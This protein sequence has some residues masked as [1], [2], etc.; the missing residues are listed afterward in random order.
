MLTPAIVANRNPLKSRLALTF[1]DRRGR[2]LLSDRFHQGLFHVGKEYW[3][4]NGLTLQVLNPTAGIF[5]SDRLSSEIV[6]EQGA[7]V[8]LFSPSSSQIFTMS[9]DE[10]AEAEQN[11]YIGENACLELNPSWL[12]PHRDASFKMNTTI[13][14]S[15]SASLYYTDYLSPG[16]YAHG[17]SHDYR[18]L[19]LQQK[20]IVDDKLLS[21][22]KLHLVGGENALCI[23][24]WDTSYLAAIWA[25]S[26][27]LSDNP[28]ILRTIN[29]LQ[30]AFSTDAYIGATR[31]AENLNITR[32]IA[33]SAL[34]VKK[35]TSEIRSIYAQYMPLSNFRLTN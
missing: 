11:I 25:V 24:E 15:A 34:I 21:L 10:H 8:M 3:N 12:V 19:T 17:E 23:R 31:L 35:I 33:R 30:S 6:L 2:T 29:Q 4:D 14:M 32:I 26:P 5:G 1:C 27:G 7:H 16:R 13:S 28:G 20:L 9:E 22:E 18:E